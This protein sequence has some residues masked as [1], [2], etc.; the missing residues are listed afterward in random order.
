ML[1]LVLTS[2][3]IGFPESASRNNFTIG[4]QRFTSSLTFFQKVVD[5]TCKQ[6][7]VCLSCSERAQDTKQILS[8]DDVGCLSLLGEA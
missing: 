6:V 7:K 2:P 1:L 4:Q 3:M 8:Q 5:M